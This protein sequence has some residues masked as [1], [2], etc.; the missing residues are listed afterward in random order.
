MTLAST[1][2]LRESIFDHLQACR[3]RTLKLLSTLPGDLFS[4]QVHPNFS[5]IG[6]HFGHIAY[7][8]ALWVLE[9][10]AKFPGIFTEYHQLFAADGLPKSERQNLPS[11]DLI[12]EYLATVRSKILFY[13]DTAPVEHQERFWRWLIQHES[14]HNETIC[15]ILHLH[16]P[17]LFRKGRS[18][19]G[20]NAIHD[21]GK[22]VE[23]A[24]GELILGDD[25]SEA[26][27]NERSRHVRQLETY[28]IDIYPVTRSQYR[29][30]ILE[31]GYGRSQFWSLPGWHWKEK[32][33]IFQPLYWVDTP[34]W[35]NHP[36][37]G[38]SWYEAQAYANF[39][40]KRLPTE[41][42]W[43]KAASWDH[44]KHQKR[45]YPWGEAQPQLNLSNFDLNVGQ[46]TPV[47]THPDGRSAYGCY[48]MLGNVWEW[49][50]SWFAGYPDFTPYPY[51]GYS[52]VYFDSQ[53]RVLRGGSWATRPWCLR[54]SFRN[55][56]HPTLR[57]IF[58][59][60]RCAL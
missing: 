42:E 4:Q 11:I 55:W 43:E 33:Q 56:Y 25:G 28:W 50:D 13:L 34:E 54:N 26:Q 49:T 57:E 38:V 48:D 19:D 44:L 30:F 59:G 27:D 2:L 9:R 58:A 15:Y 35:D 52:Q 10:L 22:M 41:A 5:P 47:N 37:Y 32:H 6:W 36:V 51:P 46:T 3:D 29:E 45:S 20:S 21:L 53:H 7:T 40:G 18:P 31:R 39:V 12:Q 8:E 17:S 1:Q 16:L 24:A 60:F 14:Q 23:I